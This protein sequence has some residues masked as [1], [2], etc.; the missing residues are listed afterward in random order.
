MGRQIARADLQPGDIVYFYTPVSHVAIYLGNGAMI[1]ARTFGQPVSVT[2][3][4][5]AGYR[6]AVRIIG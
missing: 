1:E 4:D 3:V 6:G 2:S 5:R